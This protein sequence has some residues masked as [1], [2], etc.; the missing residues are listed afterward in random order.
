M[1]KLKQAIQ[2]IKIF[3]ESAQLKNEL[4]IVVKLSQK[5]TK[6]CEQEMHEVS[7]RFKSIS[8]REK[9]LK[10]LLLNSIK[11]NQWELAA[12][13]AKEIA[14]E[15]HHTMNARQTIYKSRDF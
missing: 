8:V 10:A 12:E 6:H 13:I 1:K 2:F 9:K 5:F 15:R 4:Q 14:D 3:S 7:N 11:N